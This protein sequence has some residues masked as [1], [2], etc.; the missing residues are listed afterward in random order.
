MRRNLLTLALAPVLFPQG[1]WTRYRTPILPEPPGDRRGAA[2]N[3]PELDLLVAGAA[4][5]AGVGAAH[6]DEA[7]LGQL[8]SRLAP[9]RRVRYRLEATT[10]ATTQSTI[11]RL[12]SIGPEPCDVAVLSL[13][14]NDVTRGVSVARWLEQQQELRRFLREGCGAR[15]IVAC[16]L[17]PMHGFPALP[18]PLRWY[19]GSHA[20]ALDSALRLACLAEPG[21]EYLGLRFTTDAALMAPDGFHPGPEVYSEWAERVAAI[22]LTRLPAST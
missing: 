10:G 7:L 9:S 8:V 4:A 12:Q 17:P 2:G 1:L 3:G 15:L 22:L 16:G 6:Q 20:T 18:Q 11:D 19:L 5:A 13:G 21:C 14:V